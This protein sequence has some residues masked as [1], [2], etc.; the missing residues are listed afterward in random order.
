MNRKYLFILSPPYS[1]STV[2][3]R[4]LQTA[5]TVAALPDEGQKLPEL[6]A[7]M[8]DDPWNPR[9]EFDWP[10][11]STVWHRY[12]D[13]QRPVLLEKSPPHLCR[14]QQLQRHFEP[15]WFI[16]LLRDPLACCEALHRRNGMSYADAIGRW[17]SWLDLHLAARATLPGSITLYYED[18]VD[19]PTESFARLARWLPEL[20]AVDANAP[21]RAH[22][23]DGEQT[24]PLTNLNPEK[25]ARISDADRDTVLTALR[26]RQAAL[27]ATP[28]AAVHLSPGA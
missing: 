9:R 28:Y 10:A 25:L 12:W 18:L 4:L 23:V 19:A 13:L 7:M 11:I 6:R 22:A 2:L 1:G 24:R 5:P 14:P 20:A 21:V 17:L 16:L 15:A 8:R 27:A 26:T 3:W